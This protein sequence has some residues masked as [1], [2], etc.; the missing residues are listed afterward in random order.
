LL[1][2]FTASRIIGEVVLPFDQTWQPLSTCWMVSLLVAGALLAE[3]IT[4]TSP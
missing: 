3:A 4:P 1:P 2:G